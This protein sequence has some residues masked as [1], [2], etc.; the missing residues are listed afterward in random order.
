MLR[1]SLSVLL[2]GLALA[3][4]RS[5]ANNDEE[6]VRELIERRNAAYHNLDATTLASIE[7][8]D[9]RLV[10]RFGDN[11]GSKGPEFNEKLWRWS[12]VNVYKGKPAPVH[13]IIGVHFL[14]A[15]VAV[16]QTE[17]QWGSYKIDDGTEIPPHGEVDTFTVV[18]RAGIW[19]IAVQT[20]HN[21]FGNG[22]GD[23]FNFEGPLPGAPSKK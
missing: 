6:A 9:Y 11:I 16:V 20:I 23:D 12:F 17:T 4:A 18:R 2:V 19:K 14:T 3:G 21:R 22:I 1:V 5:I 8:P 10:D 13:N 7:T 15:D